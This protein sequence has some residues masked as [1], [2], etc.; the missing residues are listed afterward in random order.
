[1]NSTYP[2]KL[3][4]WDTV[5]WALFRSLEKLSDLRGNEVT[6]G[7]DSLPSTSARRALWVFV[8]TVGELNAIGP[9]LRALHTNLTHLKLVLITDHDHY[10]TPY[11]AQYPD[12]IV[13]V[14]GGH[15]EDAQHLARQLPPDLLVVAEIP[16]LPS[17]A[18]CR[19]SYAFMRRAKENGA[20]VALVNGW[21]YRYQPGCRMDRVESWLFGRDYLRMFDI[22]CVQNEE[23]RD[24]LIAAGASPDRLFVTGNIKFDA[25]QRPN[26]AP[27]QARSPNML[28]SL[29]GSGRPTVV[30][31]CVTDYAEQQRVVAA[32]TDLRARYPDALLVV[33]PRHPEVHEH[34][35]A[36]E[37]FLAARGL[38]GQFRSRMGDTPL[39][40]T[41]SCLVLDTIGELK[42][43]YA[44][45]TL[46]YVGV[47]HNILEPLSFA[48]PVVIG[49]GWEKTYPSYPVY[50]AML[51]SRGVV[52]IDDGESL[53]TAWISLID[54]SDAIS[55][56]HDRAGEA[57]ALAVGATKRCLDALMP[58]ISHIRA[59]K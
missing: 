58:H 3:P 25:I 33:A 35:V 37:G 31:G 21:L 26:W 11:L 54:D 14:T 45:S 10:R 57:L 38:T 53:G 39:P 12:A 40:E 42:D 5:K 6:T 18:P 59:G 17:D 41:T 1:M 23:V 50:Q 7:A 29:L 56:Q 2:T 28:T 16:C 8:S 22:A 19:F 34:M 51:A 32:F 15:G 13:F 49:P 44:A 27:N 9:F 47:D 48:K 36:L 24:Y 52:Q 43:F 30:A 4:R 55:R 20:V 46:A